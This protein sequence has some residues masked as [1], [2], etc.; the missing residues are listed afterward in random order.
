M[1]KTI[2]KYVPT[3]TALPMK[4]MP[5]ELRRCVFTTSCSHHWPV[6]RE[7]IH[8]KKPEEVFTD[9]GKRTVCI[10]CTFLL[11]FILIYRR[12]TLDIS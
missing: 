1:R 5:H 12:T 4:Q 6:P 9:N 7:D 2:N 10:G 8:L 11:G 3:A